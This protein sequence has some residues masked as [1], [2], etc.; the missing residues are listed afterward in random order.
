MSET[1]LLGRILPVAPDPRAFARLRAL[2]PGDP[3]AL[4]AALALR[5][6]D[7]APLLAGRLR[8]S[9][10]QAGR[11]EE[12]A[13]VLEK[14]HGAYAALDDT[15]V[16]RLA[17][18][19]GADAVRTALAITA[20]R[21]SEP[22][23]LPGAAALDQPVPALPFSGKQVV[24]HGVP[25]GPRVGAVLARAEALWLASGLP[26]DEAARRDIL[27]RALAEENAHTGA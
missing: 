16:R 26:E 8:L 21:G 5:T 27:S 13:L 24:A 4:L 20:A 15:A 6:C 11:L 2:E 17:F 12:I 3:L 22:G 1:G 9:N 19:H 14:A 7:D 23:P 25:P 18:T 10:A